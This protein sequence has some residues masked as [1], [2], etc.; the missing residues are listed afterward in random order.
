MQTVGRPCLR[1]FLNTA[2]L[3]LLMSLIW[4]LSS[5]SSTIRCT[6]LSCY[7]VQ[8][9]AA[10][11]TTLQALITSCCCCSSSHCHKGT[12][13]SKGSELTLRLTHCLLCTLLQLDQQLSGPSPSSATAA[14]TGDGDSP[15]GP[16]AA[17]IDSLVQQ[18]KQFM[19]DR[20]QQQQQ[21][22][23]R[24]GYRAS[25]A[26]LTPRQGVASPRMT[27]ASPRGTVSPGTTPADTAGHS[28]LLQQQ[29]QQREQQQ[30]AE[31]LL[32][33]AQQAAW[34]AAKLQLQEEKAQVQEQV[35]AGCCYGYKVL[36]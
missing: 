23:H 4:L 32:H 25:T 24:G 27:Q 36:S 14:A 21:Q 29:R 33:L 31:G 28:L 34:E 7:Q 18:C 16:E 2:T 11:A 8:Q 1:Q 10:L 35:C 19:Q 22:Q 20:Q 6:F 3:Y 13:S 15:A 5:L 9:L 12:S 30:D 26:Q 17:D